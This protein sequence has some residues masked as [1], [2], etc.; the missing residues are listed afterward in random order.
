MADYQ[1]TFGESLPPTM[2]SWWKELSN[3]TH[4]LV[5]YVVGKL[6]IGGVDVSV[7]NPFPITDSWNVATYEDEDLNDSDKQ[8]V[9]PAGYEM[10]IL[11]VYIVYVSDANAGNRQ[12]QISYHD[13]DTTILG[14]VRAG[15][16]QAASLTYRYMF[17]PSLADLLAVRDTTFVMT[18]MPP[19]IILTAGQILRMYNNSVISAGDDMSV[20]VQYALHRV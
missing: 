20:Y 2:R 5:R 13:A 15:L 4:A 11:W 17:A 3:G 10:Q 18:P 8:M 16:T 6:Q 7:T 9:C 12:I 14:E 1:P 19:T